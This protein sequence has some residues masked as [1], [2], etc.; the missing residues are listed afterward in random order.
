MEERNLMK[1]SA[2]IGSSGLKYEFVEAIANG[3]SDEVDTH[4]WKSAFPVGK[5]TLEA[6]IDEARLVDFGIFIFGADDRLADDVSV[7]RDNVVYE[8]GLFAGVLGTDRC[9]IVHEKKAKRPTDLKGMTVASFLGSDSVTEFADAVCPDLLKA[10][11]K[12]RAKRFETV[13]ST[14]EGDWWQFSWAPDGGIERAKVSFLRFRR[15]VSGYLKFK[16]DAWT[17]NGDRLARFKSDL[18]I[19]NEQHRT[20]TYDW[21]GRWFVNKKEIKAEP[22]GF[23]GSGEFSLSP[24]NSD[25]ASGEYTTRND[26]NRD[27]DD[28]TPVEYRRANPQD[29]QI[30]DGDDFSARR[31]LI[32]QR[33]AERLADH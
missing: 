22:G 4:P 1:P 8:A 6:L 9:L 15:T 27:L 28:Q 20:F 21:T 2:F 11:R 30:M 10:I 16:G 23:Y 13:A 14:I 31:K 19:V 33:L 5:M 26:S 24:S 7:P 12:K 17:E 29:I 3:L 18:S 25:R 32:Q